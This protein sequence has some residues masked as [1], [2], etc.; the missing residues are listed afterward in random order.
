MT[1]ALETVDSHGLASRHLGVAAEDELAIN[2][3]EVLEEMPGRA[4]TAYVS[5]PDSAVLFTETVSHSLSMLFAVEEPWVVLVLGRAVKDFD[6]SV[7][8][9]FQGT[10][11]PSIID[12]IGPPLPFQAKASSVLLCPARR[13]W[14]VNVFGCPVVIPG[15]QAAGSP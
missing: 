7:Q 1:T 8:P 15:N 10:H 5:D 6:L 3:K 9:R 11:Q 12:K 4:S 13:L 14:Y 2:L